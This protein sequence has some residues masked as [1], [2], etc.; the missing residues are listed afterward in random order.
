METRLFDFLKDYV[1]G[2][3]ST[4][5]DVTDKLV[6]DMFERRAVIDV[7][8]VGI[9]ASKTV[10]RPEP[11]M[12]PENLISVLGIK[13]LRGLG[14]NV[15]YPVVKG[16]YCNWVSETE[17]GT[18]LINDTVFS[19]IVLKPK[20][21]L[22]Y[23][24]YDRDIIVSSDAEIQASLE[25]DLIN[26]MWEKVQESCLNGIF[27]TTAESVTTLED[28]ED[29]INFELQASKKKIKNPVY[30]VSPDAAAKLKGLTT[31]VFPVV[32][33]GMINGYRMIETPSLS[34]EKIIFGDFSK[35]VIGQFGQT[36]FTID[37]TTQAHNGIVR[38]IINTYWDWGVLDED[39]LIFGTTETTNQG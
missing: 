4:G 15:G 38:L 16:N 11:E 10:Y 34:G 13:F 26:A 33:N 27:P 23:L 30:L 35:L 29:I 1:N 37:S 8:T 31:S 21:L 20:R 17:D 28:Y 39:G 6:R 14:L 9:N 2:K 25:D 3:T 36:D 5:R 18:E 24:E 22:S 32:F 12:R 19:S 7:N